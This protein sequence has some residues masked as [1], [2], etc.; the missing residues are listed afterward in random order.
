MKLVFNF[1]IVLLTLILF[2][3][4]CVE[5]RKHEIYRVDHFVVDSF[6]LENATSIGKNYFMQRYFF[7]EDLFIFNHL[8]NKL[9]H[10]TKSDTNSYSYLESYEFD[11]FGQTSV[12]FPKGFKASKEQIFLVTTQKKLL[13]Y[14]LSLKD[15][16]A[17]LNI[18]FGSDKTDFV[19]QSSTTAQ[20]FYALGEKT[21]T[22]N[23]YI[24]GD[25]NP[26]KDIFSTFI[27]TNKNAALL[28]TFGKQHHDRLTLGTMFPKY[29]FIPN[30][31]RLI[32]VYSYW[33]SLFVVSPKM[34]KNVSLKNQYH[35]KNDKNLI[36]RIAKCSS[37]EEYFD[38]IKNCYQYTNI[39]Y[40]MDSKSLLVNI[41]LPAENMHEWKTQP[42]KGVFLDSSLNVLRY[43]DYDGFS[44]FGNISTQD[45]QHS[46]IGTHIRADESD[47]KG[48]EKFFMLNFS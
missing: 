17:S 46:S 31:N 4:S 1:L 23:R 10:Y 40:D 7:E 35:A 8:E 9:I 45:I 48:Y 22:F 11:N 18:N 15:T 30:S 34:S 33:D 28:N 16:I 13:T 5:N 3:T 38:L 29:T 6:Y 36:E 37:R 43:L 32:G 39:L 14:S 20:M 21:I 41:K 27:F 26:G 12:V 44:G 24:Y 19:P 42:M 47:K 2:F 25:Y